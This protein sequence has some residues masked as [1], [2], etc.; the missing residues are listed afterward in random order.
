MHTRIEMQRDW[1]FSEAVVVATP[2]MDIVYPV[3]EDTFGLQKKDFYVV[4]LDI[5]FS[6]SPPLPLG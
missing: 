3:F 2:V 6:A 4:G 5:D 1:H